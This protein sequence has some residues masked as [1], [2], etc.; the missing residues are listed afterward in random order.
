LNKK[1]KG[2]RHK[3]HS[4][5]HGPHG[6]CASDQH[7]PDKT[8]TTETPEKQPSNQ[9]PPMSIRT[10]IWSAFKGINPGNLGLIIAFLAF[11]TTAYQ[12]W[13]TRHTT[14]LSLRAY[15]GID[16]IELQHSTEPITPPALAD[17]VAIKFENTGGTPAFNLSVNATPYFSRTPLPQNFKYPETPNDPRTSGP[18]SHGII[19]S[20]VPE[21]FGL[22][23]TPQILDSLK[24]GEALLFVYG[25]ITYD[26]VFHVRH[27]TIYCAQ[28]Y[29]G[30]GTFGLCSNHSDEYEGDYKPME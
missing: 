24:R 23:L 3:R 4:K 21:F 15:V 18:S 12:S 1:K 8:Q 22:G 9:E 28:L 30:E 11:L 19:A 17:H 26:D 7:N 13:F 29:A 2:K 20:R 10:K 14:Q 6:F 16:S 5:K 25:H 27:T